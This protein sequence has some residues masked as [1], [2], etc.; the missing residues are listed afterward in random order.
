MHIFQFS[1]VAPSGYGKSANKGTVK[2]LAIIPHLPENKGQSD[3][4]NHRILNYTVPP[5][6]RDIPTS[7]SPI[8]RSKG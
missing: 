6:Y 8:M 2:F 5:T 7:H 4:S 3:E 1:Y